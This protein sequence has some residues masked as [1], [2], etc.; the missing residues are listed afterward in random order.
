VSKAW[1]RST[2][3]RFSFLRCT[4]ISF[5]DGKIVIADFE[6]PFKIV[7]TPMSTISSIG[8]K[9][10]LSGQ[11]HYIFNVIGIF[12]SRTICVFSVLAQTIYASEIFEGKCDLRVS[13]MGS[14]EVSIR[15]FELDWNTVIYQDKITFSEAIGPHLTA[16]TPNKFYPGSTQLL[17]SGT[18]IQTDCHCV[19]GAARNL[20]TSVSFISGGPVCHVPDLSWV[21]TPVKAGL[22][23]QIAVQCDSTKNLLSESVSILQL[24]SFSLTNKTIVVTEDNPILMVTGSN[25]TSAFTCYLTVLGIT[26]QTKI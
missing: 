24:N 4:D 17:L 25:L 1:I 26:S 9:I 7:D 2:E 8:P 20:S 19:F 10:A 15:V 23:S 16:V 13:A 21:G 14:Q 22:V 11:T 5:G 12:N 18:G 3:G 6:L